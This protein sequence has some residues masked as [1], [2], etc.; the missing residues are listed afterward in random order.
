[1]LYQR[2]SCM[3]FQGKAH[4]FG[5]KYVVHD[6]WSYYI[7]PVVKRQPKAPFVV[8]RFD[9]RITFDKISLLLL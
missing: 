2:Q 3:C 6:R 1:M 9:C 7:E 4:F 8:C 5:K